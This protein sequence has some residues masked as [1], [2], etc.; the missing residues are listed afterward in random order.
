MNSVPGGYGSLPNEALQALAEVTA[1]DDPSII[2]IILTGSAGRGMATKYSDVDVIVVRDEGNESARE[3]LHSPAIDEIPMTLAE[4][5]NVKPIGSEGAWQRWSFAWAK[6]LRDSLGGRISDAVRRQAIL[7]DQEIQHILIGRLSLDEFINF[8][9]RALKSHRAGQIEA[10]RLDSAESIAS[11][12]DV[13]FA[14]SGRVRP[15]NKY[16]AW[17][18]REHPLPAVDWQDGRLLQY[19]NG[20]LEG[21][22]TAIRE[23]FIAVE[24]VCRAYDQQSGH[25]VLSEVIDAWGEELRLM[26]GQ[27]GPLAAS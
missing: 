8:I 13:V 2:G 14:L 3:V 17:E 11:M 6:V 1:R 25:G 27:P 18:L 16:L 22:E 4:L 26:R 5:E 19:V 24:R 10:A 15:Y 21:S 7:S 12:L 20:L 23:A 9:Y